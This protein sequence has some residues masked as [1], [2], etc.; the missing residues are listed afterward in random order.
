MNKVRVFCP[1]CKGGD[2]SIWKG[3]LEEWGEELLT[4]LR[5]NESAQKEEGQ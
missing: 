5:A 3:S 1:I 2:N 4:E